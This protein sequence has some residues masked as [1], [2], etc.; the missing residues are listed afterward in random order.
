MNRIEIY[1]QISRLYADLAV[2]EGAADGAGLLP[3]VSRQLSPAFAALNMQIAPP[4]AVP[5]LGDVVYVLTEFFTTFNGSWEVSDHIYGVPPWAR[6]RYLRS[7][8]DPDYI[9]DGG[10]D[11]DLFARV[12]GLDGSPLRGVTVSFRNSNTVQQV[13]PKRSGWAAIPIWSYFAPERDE[14]GAYAWRPDDVLA[15]TLSGGGMPNKL[16]VSMFAVW[17]AMRA[18]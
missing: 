9:D 18:E 15:E 7:P 2:L 3:A 12:V 6:A 16:H 5:R 10:A 1:Q 4:A 11:H 14:R 8:G 13:T 17:Q